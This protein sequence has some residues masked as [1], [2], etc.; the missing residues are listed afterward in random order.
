MYRTGDLAAR[1]EDGEFEFHGRVDRQVKIRGFRVE[2]GEVET[3]LAAHPGVSSAVADV[4]DEGP[5]LKRLAAFV[6]PAPGV[7]V[8]A[9]GLLRYLSEKLPAYL[10]PAGL[11]LL[12]EM[13][14]DPNGKPDRRALPYPWK[15]R[16]D[17]GLEE[18]YV[19]P[20]TPR[21]RAMAQVWT[22][23]LGLDTVGVDDN[24]FQ[25]GGDSLRSVTLLSRL[26]E[27]NIEVV[28]DDLFDYQTIAE[29]VAAVDTGRD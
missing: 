28:P 29:L 21:E 10:Q 3:V 25:L 14:R 12:T 6:V 9:A 7:E 15:R 5:D 22:E 27:Q 11:V 13:P 18:A 2:P 8:T 20:R 4:F 1:L 17:L 24:F 19:A 23:V 16:A 26:N